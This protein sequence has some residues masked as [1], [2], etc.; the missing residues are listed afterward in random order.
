MLPLA[1][2]TDVSMVKN[3]LPETPAPM[4]LKDFAIACVKVQAS[5]VWVCL[6][7]GQKMDHRRQPIVLVLLIQVF[8]NFISEQMTFPGFS[9]IPLV[10]SPTINTTS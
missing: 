9:P 8:A 3:I 5:H 10:L 1:H 2:M 4:F 6:L 7:T